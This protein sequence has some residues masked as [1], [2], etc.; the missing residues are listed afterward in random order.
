MAAGLSGPGRLRFGGVRDFVLGVRFLDGLG[1]DRFGGGKVV[2][3]AAGFDIPKLMVG[4]LGELGAMLELTFKVFPRPRTYRTVELRASSLADSVALLTRLAN[5][6]LECSALEL[7]PPNRVWARFGGFEEAV[8]ARL[9]RLLQFVEQVEPTVLSE[10]EDLAFWR[11]AR[12]FA[13]ATPESWLVKAPITSHDIGAFEA[14]LGSLAPEPLRRY[15]VAG[16]IAWIA[17][18][19]ELGE[20]KL[21]QVCETLERPG[22]VIRGEVSDPR[23][24]WRDNALQQRLRKVFDPASRFALPKTTSARLDA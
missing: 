4:A 1:E 2:K 18:P 21:R 15:S 14:A 17:W 16:N 20:L 12:Q 7:A 6:P 10:A 8:E 3:N 5:S 13:W 24:A 23:L 11:D 19:S 22:L 9:R